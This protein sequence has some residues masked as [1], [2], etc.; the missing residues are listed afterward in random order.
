MSF[1]VTEYS[2]IANWLLSFG[3][4]IQIMYPADLRE[5][6]VGIVSKLKNIYVPGN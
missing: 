5:Y 2:Y 4:E 1:A 6:M 3:S